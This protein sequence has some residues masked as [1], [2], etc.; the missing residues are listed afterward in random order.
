[1]LACGCASTKPASFTNSELASQEFLI[2]S[3]IRAKITSTGGL[4]IKMPAEFQSSSEEKLQ[5]TETDFSIKEGLPVLKRFLRRNGPVTYL[6]SERGDVEISVP[7]SGQLRIKI[8]NQSSD[9][10]MN[11]LEPVKL[12]EPVSIDIEGDPKLAATLN[13][14]LTELR[15]GTTRTEFPIATFGMGPFGL[16]AEFYNGHTFWDADVWMLP[17]LL[18]TEPNAAKAIAEYRL[19]KFE[20]AKKNAAVFFKGK[21]PGAAM[22]PWESSV[23]GK[24]S[25]PGPSQKEHHISGSVLWGLTQAQA[26]GIVESSKVIPVA[27]AI[28]KFYSARSVPGSGRGRELLDTMSPDEHH[29]GN[30]DLYTNLLAQWSMNGRKWEGPTVFYLPKFDQTFLTYDNDSLRGY[31]QAAAVL[32]IYPLEFPPAESQA[33]EMMKRF[34]SKI[35]KNGPAMS[36]SVHS[37]I[38]S[39]LGKKDFALAAFEKSLSPFLQPNLEF[40]EKRKAVRTF[41]YTGAAGVLNSVIYGFAGIRL[42]PLSRKASFST[43]LSSGWHLSIQPCVPERFKKLTLKNFVI[44]GKR[45]NIECL[46]SGS[47]NVSF[48]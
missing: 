24:E 20:Q 22:Y 29:T 14:L 43:K 12:L 45:A 10:P 13:A 4:S 46:P 18:F 27:E 33:E 9:F 39:R 34:E 32:A 11:G 35:I 28:A 17:A 38:W 40:S 36:E 23:T 25:I 47:V 19:G 3:G 37:I 2:G 7:K 31:K 26:A 41:F 30:N 44:D 1:V 16:S 6:S 5:F 42:G 15:T 48:L 21:A 8:G